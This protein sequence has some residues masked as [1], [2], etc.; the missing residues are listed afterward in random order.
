MVQI[1]GARVV[2][3]AFEQSEVDTLWR[4]QQ[5]PAVVRWLETGHPESLH[6]FRSRF[7][8]NPH[9]S[10]ERLDL[11][12]ETRE[13]GELVGLVALRGAKP[14]LGDAELAV[15]IG[16]TGHWGRGLATDAVRTMC[17]YGFDT[18]RLHK[19]WLTVY[20]DN[21]GARRVYDK[22]GFVE[23]G[24]LREGY[25]SGGAWHDKVVMGLFAHELRD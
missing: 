24:R 20:P 21:H 19:I 22:V 23:E 12:I 3:R 8:A 15:Y 18:M 14:E 9:D 10:Y 5:D 2:L 25:R 13:E 7:E 16:E 4:W 17:R 11:A 1:M 6:R